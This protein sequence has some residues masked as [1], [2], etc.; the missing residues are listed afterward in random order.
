MLIIYSVSDV[1]LCFP[2]FI[3]SL[4]RYLL[5]AYYVSSVACTKRYGWNHEQNK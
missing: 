4:S 1:M 3:L 5:I 2:E